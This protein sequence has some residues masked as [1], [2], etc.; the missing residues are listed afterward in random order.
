MTDLGPRIEGVLDL[1]TRLATGD[2]AARGT[3]S[4]RDDDIDAV[5]EG[6]NMLAEE[7]Q[8]SQA[9]LEAR[10][11]DRTAELESINRDVL[12]L[13]EVGNMLQ[14][15]ETADE[16]YAVTS[17]GLKSIFVG[18]AGAVY[19]YRSSRN[20]LELKAAWGDSTPELS[21]DPRD[22]WALRRG[23]PHSVDAAR[24]ALRCAHLEGPVVDTVCVPMFAQGETTGMLYLAATSRGRLQPAKRQLA[25]PVA[26]QVSMALANLDLR[27]KLRM[28]SIKDPLTGL[29]NRRFVDEWI[30]REVARSSRTGRCLGVIMIDI[31]HFKQINDLHGHHAGD[32]LLQEIARGLEGSVRPGDMPCRYGGEEFLVL[33]SETDLASLRDRAE[34]LREVISDIR[35]LHEGN[36]LPGV[37]ASAGI[38]AFPDHGTT[39]AGV[40]GAADA[41]LYAAKRAGRNRVLAAS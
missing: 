7:L 30:E 36:T 11:L 27:D 26:E 24:P 25:A 41:A 21:L 1:V 22:C 8:A 35:V 33:M 40:I 37:T 18:L 10:V 15:C 12:R 6:I 23:H 34:K 29:H 3:R 16:A 14:A 17:E 32:L 19:L 20:V 38:A 9:E 2:L 39:A 4:S 31:D 28:Q 13:A 5:I